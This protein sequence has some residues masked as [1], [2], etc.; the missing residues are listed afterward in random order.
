M[1]YGDEK[2][3]VDV[4]DINN[5]EILYTD[6]DGKETTYYPCRSIWLEV[7]TLEVLTVLGDPKDGAEPPLVTRVR[8]T[9]ALEDQSISVVGDPQSKVHTLTISFDAGD[10]TPKPVEPKEGEFP[11]FHGEL[12]GAMLGFN[13]ADWEIGNDD[14]WWISC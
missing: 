4:K 13:R 14:D 11:S 8:G 3:I 7:Q 12:G 2:V 5:G 6:K 10:W 9:A 1:G